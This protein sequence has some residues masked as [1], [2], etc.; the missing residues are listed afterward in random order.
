M[1]M[2]VPEHDVDKKK[3]IIFFYSKYN[4]RLKMWICLI[5]L[6]LF[7]ILNSISCRQ[8]IKGAV[9]CSIPA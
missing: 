8:V 7:L 9:G 2:C 3:L 4:R 6:Y 5:C 1:S